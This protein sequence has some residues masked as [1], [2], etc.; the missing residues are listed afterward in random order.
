MLNKKI[1]GCKYIHLYPGIDAFAFKSYSTPCQPLADTP[2]AFLNSFCDI[3]PRYFRNFFFDPPTLLSCFQRNS[4]DYFCFSA[5][6]L[7]VNRYRFRL[8]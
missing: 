6:D 2:K 7:R 3:R 1:L 4:N 5:S 8:H